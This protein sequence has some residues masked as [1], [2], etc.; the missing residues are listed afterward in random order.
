M[1][2]PRHLTRP[3]PA[4]HGDLLATA[5][6][7]PGH[8]GIAAPRGHGKS[9]MLDLVL[10]AWVIA[11]GLRNFLLVISDTY[12]QA[13]E[14]VNT[15]KFELEFN[16]RFRW[17]YGD[18][19]TSEWSAGNF[20]TRNDA[21]VLALGQGMKV[22][23]QKHRQHRPQLIIVDDL[24]N[25][26]MVESLQRRRKVRSWFTK[27]VLPS[28]D[29]DGKIIVIGT[30][31]HWDSLLRNIVERRDE[32]ASWTTRK[33]RALIADG[34]G[35]RA[36][37]PELYSL[38][39]LKAMRDDPKHPKYL[40]SL[41]FSQEYQNEPRGEEDLIFQPA[42]IRWYE[43]A[44]LPRKP[45]GA[46][47]F[48]LT[49]MAV[50]PAISKKETADFTAIV[51]IGATFQSE[52]V[53]RFH[54]LETRNARLNFGEQVAAVEELYARWKPDVVGIETVAYQEALKEKLS[55]LP[56]QELKPDQDKVR[57][58]IS[59]SSYFQGGSVFLR[60]TQTELYDQLANFTGVGD[61][62]DDLVDAMVYAVLLATRYRRRFHAEVL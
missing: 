57:R 2:F 36:L 60:R 46:L 8:V 21:R 52:G 58:A 35:E 31:L 37:W 22:R 18:L 40:G 27:A 38:S 54:V 28:L 41:V 50:D 5:W 47:D 20:V 14:Y 7:T 17:L 44:E 4:F 3:A 45:D 1:C 55:H 61:A 11:Y 30:I 56:V 34:N 25:D 19:T 23:G 59:A 26:E 10:P 32:F 12:T 9:T 48:H 33:H 42:W 24:E 43:D 6:T 53:P 29:K 49:L 13:E 16:E 15:L 51:V 62:H 39:D